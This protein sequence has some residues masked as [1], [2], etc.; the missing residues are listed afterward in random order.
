MTQAQLEVALAEATG[1][2]VRTIRR[3]GFSI[4]DPRAS[5]FDPDPNDL[6]PQV[7]DWDLL[8]SANY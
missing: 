6:P 5:D 8:A 1:E 2:S 4:I 7:V 3:H